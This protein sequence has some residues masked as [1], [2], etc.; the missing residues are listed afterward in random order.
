MLP[1]YDLIPRS[2]GLHAGLHFRAVD[3]CL[4]I[5]CFKV[6]S[7]CSLSAGSCSD[8]QDVTTFSPVFVTVNTVS[9][10]TYV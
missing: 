7:S 6:C 9:G 2:R 5:I 8:N 1:G 3:V 10:F 4:R